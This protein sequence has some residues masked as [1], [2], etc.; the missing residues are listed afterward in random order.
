MSKN[1][2]HFFKPRARLLLQLGDQLIKDE[3]LALFELVK[4]SYD[5]DATYS[6]VQLNDIDKKDI[7]TITIKDNGS[8][9]NYNLITNHWLEPGTDI[10]EEL[11]QKL[12]KSNLYGRLPL[13]EKGIGR[14]GSHKL[15][16]K[17]TLY[18]K[19]DFDPEVEININW[20]TFENEKYLDSVPIDIKENTDIPEFFKKSITFIEEENYK[21]ILTN[22]E[23][24]NDINFLHSLYALENGKMKLSDSEILKDQSLYPK[25]KI[26]LNKAGYHTSGTYIKISNLWENWSRGML[27][28]T[29]RAVNAINSPFAQKN[30]DFIVSIK[31]TQQHWLESLLTT[32]EAINKA[33]F[34]AQG[35]IEGNT[36]KFNYKFNPMDGMDK[37]TGRE[38][39]NEYI[40]ESIE[41]VLNKNTGTYKKERIEYNIDE[42][43]IGKVEFEFYMYDLSPKTLD[44]LEYDKTGFK[45]FLKTNGGIRVYRDKVRV[46]DYG[47]P[48]NDWLNL[49]YKRLTA[50]T[51]AISNNQILGAIYLD[52]EGSQ[53]LIEK[54]N[55][56]GFV[57]NFA[58]ELFTKAV[59]ITIGKIAQE[60]VI[61]KT[62]I[63]DT[64]GVNRKSEPV[65]STI[66][67][68]DKY[69]EINLD[70]NL[71]AKKK[72]REK[73]IEIEKE[74]QNITENL[75]SAAG[76]GL[77]LNIAIHE[78]EKIIAEMLRR[79][80]ED[81]LD[82]EMS[83][84]VDQLHTTLK[85]YSELSKFQ[86]NENI[87]LKGTINKAI[88]LNAYR[89]YNHEIEVINNSVEL[90]NDIN[91]KF[92]QKLLLASISNIIDN[93]IFWLDNKFIYQ[94]R[95]DNTKFIKKIYIDIL[96]ENNIPSIIIADNGTGFL[97][98]TDLI[99]KPYISKK[100]DSMGLG[101]YIIDETM[102]LHKGQV[103]FP[104][105][106][107]VAVPDEF[108]DGAIIQLKFNIKD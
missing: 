15:G 30:N 106:G 34:I 48:G 88:N 89:L 5:A 8:G 51:Q 102:K 85:H 81:T 10:K 92:T 13:G 50:P 71:P 18:S 7:G 68:L 52:R 17:I 69:I 42:Y 66:K 64:Y 77:S 14:F 108:Q 24:K 62:I 60:R 103:I 20:K 105:K 83:Y 95:N 36:I 35:C 57:D 37:L 73:L 31:T 101:L 46:Y 79:V 11:I 61:D 22:I 44:F 76:S 93:S 16:Q 45:K 9:M 80:N 98:P 100:D 65:I 41:K 27:R 19:T 47:E 3:G 1:K 59:L 90:E 25:L 82:S 23:H 21:E 58:Y 6:D 74:Y 87:S 26:L 40:I 56:E 55:R 49:D 97:I 67:D 94:S 2:Q 84:L 86:K 53:D 104:D 63:K 28:N 75:L 43:K 91:I 29:F 32:E 12:S 96:I 4:N 33:L 107:D 39:N 54:T 72:I 99:K 78:I 38:T 70:D